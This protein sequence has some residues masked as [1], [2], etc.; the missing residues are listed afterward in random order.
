MNHCRRSREAWR[1]YEYVDFMQ[2][3]GAKD[4]MVA[5]CRVYHKHG[6]LFYKGPQARSVQE[7]V[8]S[9]DILKPYRKISGY[10][11]LA[12][13]PFVFRGS[14]FYCTRMKEPYDEFGPW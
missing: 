8:E 7:L 6:R 11:L 4:K 2:Y 14:Y 5:V 10:S 12:R 1:N 13:L 3:D 9:Y